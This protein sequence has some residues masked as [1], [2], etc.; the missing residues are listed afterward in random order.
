MQNWLPL[1]THDK[2]RFVLFF[3]F[4]F[5]FWST[6]NKTTTSQ[7]ATII[8]TLQKVLTGEHD[9]MVGVHIYFIS[10]SRSVQKKHQI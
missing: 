10:M 2:Y 3:F 5:F 8:K 9:D 4:F 6:R 7:C 1:N